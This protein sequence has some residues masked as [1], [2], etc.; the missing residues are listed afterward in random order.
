M[1]HRRRLFRAQARPLRQHPRHHRLRHERALVPP[2]VGAAQH[3]ALG[4]DHLGR[5]V[6]RLARGGAPDLDH[7]L[8]PVQPL[9]LF[10]DRV[11]IR[12]ALGRLG[13]APDELAPLDHRLH[14]QR[15]GQARLGQP[16]YPLG[17]R[18]RPRRTDTVRR[19]PHA[20]EHGLPSPAGLFELAPPIR[21]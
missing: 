6:Y 16:L 17:R 18:A 12:L 15:L 1:T 7:R 2:G 14:R 20:L 11:G 10:Q 19:H 9:H 5:R 21:L 13:D 8:V 3:P 4:R